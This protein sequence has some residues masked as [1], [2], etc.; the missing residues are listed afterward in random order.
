MLIAI[1]SSRII[2]Y[3]L[4]FLS[5]YLCSDYDASSPNLFVRWDAVYFEAISTRG[6]KY[7][8]EFAFFPLVPWLWKIPSLFYFIIA[9]HYLKKLV[10][11]MGYDHQLANGCVLLFCVSPASIFLA[12][13][14]TETLFCALSFAGMYF[15]LIDKH[16]LYTL[17][18]T[19]AN[20]ARSNGLLYAGFPLYTL[21]CTGS[22]RTIPSIFVI[23]MPYFALQFYLYNLS[24][25]GRPWCGKQMPYSFIQ[26][27]YWNNGF[28]RYY[29]LNNIPNFLFALPSLVILFNTVYSFAARD[30]FSFILLKRGK[31]A[32]FY[33]LAAFM[34]LY[35]L[36]F[37]HVQVAIRFDSANAVSLQVFL[38]C[39]C[40]L[41]STEYDGMSGTA[42]HGLAW[43]AC[44]M[45]ISILQHEQKV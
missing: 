30:F 2:L 45:P 10:L 24:C 8:Q 28:L 36:F 17:C 32:A 1:A 3:S 22:L 35:C 19:A 16:L 21:L 12:S 23:P 18:F 5:N 31:Q 38:C 33:Y 15:Y 34:G 13:N 11:A 43:A 37:M 20:S 40:T 4:A 42:L 44:C 9:C 25:P 6:Y 39:T 41:L 14:Y 27:E 26:W 29:T 7:E